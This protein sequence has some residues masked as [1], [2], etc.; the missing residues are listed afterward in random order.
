M[1]DQTKTI[2]FNDVCM[3]QHAD[4]NL[5]FHPEQPLVS[6]PLVAWGSHIHLCIV[7]LATAA[8]TAE[9]YQSDLRNFCRLV[10]PDFRLV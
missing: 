1:H 5:L 3:S 4:N 8:A 7:A 2:A 10:L 6:R 9:N